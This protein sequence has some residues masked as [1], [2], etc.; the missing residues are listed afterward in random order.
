VEAI[1]VEKRGREH[2]GGLLHGDRRW[3]ARNN[4]EEPEGRLLARLVGSVRCSAARWML[5]R[6]RLV[7]RTAIQGWRQ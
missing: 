5:S 3:P 2:P 1:W 7:R 4:G 6:W